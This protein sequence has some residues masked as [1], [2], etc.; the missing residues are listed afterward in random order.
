MAADLVEQLRQ[1]GHLLRDDPPPDDRPL[2]GRELPHPPDVLVSPV[3]EKRKPS[4]RGLLVAATVVALTVGLLGALVA[5]NQPPAEP[6][7]TPVAAPS[8]VAPQPNDTPELE[9]EFATIDYEIV[10]SGP[11]SATEQEADAVVRFFERAAIEVDDDSVRVVLEVDEGP[12]VFEADVGDDVRTDDPFDSNRCRV[13]ITSFSTGDQIGN[14]P[15]SCWNTEVRPPPTED[16]R[17]QLAY[18]CDPAYGIPGGVFGKRDFTAEIDLPPNAPAAIFTLENGKRVLVRPVRD[19]VSY[20]GPPA[21][22]VE[23]FYAD[24]QTFTDDLSDC[25]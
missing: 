21:A 10:S 6:V 17:P 8:D 4:R 3:V 15:F 20:A 22:S 18:G 12:T 16:E 24:G 23:V 13:T 14:E 11:R 1:Y 5:V 2:D 19:L 7:A 9:A 25:L